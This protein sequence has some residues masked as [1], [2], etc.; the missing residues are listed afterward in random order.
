MPC[1]APARAL[2]V[3]SCSF[4]PK[5]MDCVLS[6]APRGARGT[7]SCGQACKHVC[8]LWKKKYRLPACVPQQ[9]CTRFC[10]LVCT[11]SGFYYK[12]E[13][14]YCQ[15]AQGNFSVWPVFKVFLCASCPFIFARSPRFLTVL[16][17]FLRF[18]SLGAAF[19]AACRPR[20][21][22][23][24]CLAQRRALWYRMENRS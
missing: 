12:H 10:K 7:Q 19:F 11:S 4:P 14:I 21:G 15:C 3:F 2:T 17:L 6:S 1:T 18:F 13:W 5:F 23:R 22:S 8:T 24:A 9:C 20:P 16:L